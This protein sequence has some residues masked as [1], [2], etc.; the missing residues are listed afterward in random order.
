[1]GCRE[2]MNENGGRATA[3]T[4][5]GE[6]PALSKMGRIWVGGAESA[7]LVCRRRAAQK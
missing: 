1:M 7:G 4:T 5:G 6:E 3:G 2:R